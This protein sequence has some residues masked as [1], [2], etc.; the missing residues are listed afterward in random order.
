MLSLTELIKERKQKEKDRPKSMSKEQLEEQVTDWCDFY[1]KNWDVYARYELGIE[2]L[3]TFQLYILY[4]MGTSDRFFLMCGRGLGKS[5][6]SALGAFIKCLLYPNSTVVITATTIPTATKMVKNKMEG[7]LCNNF[8]PKLKYL[9]DNGYIKF[10]YGDKG[11]GVNFTFNNSKILVLPEVEASAGERATL[12]IFEEVRLSKANIINRIFMPMKYARPAGYRLKDEYK[13][14]KALTEKAQVIYLTSTSYTF[15]WWFEKWKMCVSGFFNKNSRLRYGIFCGDIITSIYHG[16]TSKEEFQAEIDDPTVSQEQIDMEYYNAPQGGM[17][18]AFYNMQKMKENSIITNA[19]VPPTYEDFVLKYD[20]DRDNSYR[21]K[22]RDEVRAIVVDFASSDTV[23]STQE[24]D[25]TV[26]LCMSGS[27]NKNK[28]H[29][30]RNIDRVETL[31]G[32]ARQET[33]LRIRELFYFYKADVF[34]YDNQ[35]TG[36][37][38]FQELSKPFYHEQLGVHMNGFGILEDLSMTKNFCEENKVENLRT[39]VIDS[40]YIP[41]A[42]PV[43]GISERNQNFHVAMQKAI[44]QKIMLFLQDSTQAR[45][46]YEENPEWILKL[47]EEKAN[48]M[49]GYIQT[50]AM[51]VEASELQK[52]IKNGYIKLSE[53][54]HHPK[55]RIVTATYGN[56]YFA[57]LEVKMLQNDQE[58]EDFNEDEWNWLKKINNRN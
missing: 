12:L 25:N 53:I 10:S 22:G 45:N 5:F 34:I 17:E 56:Y 54:P 40:N 41:V 39:K 30:I 43:V 2:A 57:M 27:P 23:V 20:S 4:L 36:F 49:L 58:D 52:E 21:E 26:I 13:G 55:D 44:E 51:L 28:T 6:L 38:R 37:D 1:R 29:I 33:L 14:I 50:N 47:S 15:E 3:Y 24:N 42:I 16:F 46:R 48:I 32:G 35:Q 7:E 18:G 8:S 19:F 11:I 31:S 9:Y